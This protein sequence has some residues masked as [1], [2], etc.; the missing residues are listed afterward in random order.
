M[1]ILDKVGAAA[2]IDENREYLL[3]DSHFSDEFPGIYEFLARVR[4]NGK[5]RKPG[6][7]ILYY[8]PEKAQLCL[9]DQHTKSVAWHAAKGLQEALEGVEKRLQ[10][11]SVDW[12]YDK[13]ARN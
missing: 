3:E 5:N 11:G 9:S 2:P 12:R 10:A 13:R 1:S 7:L 6:K 8:E 4:I